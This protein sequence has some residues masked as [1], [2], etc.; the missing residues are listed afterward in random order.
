MH[1]RSLSAFVAVLGIL[2]LSTAAFGQFNL[3]PSGMDGN[4]VPDL[5]YDM[6]TGNITLNSDGSGNIGL[7]QLLSTSGAFTGDA[8]ALPA[9]GLFP[10]DTDME[11]AKAAFA[12]VASLNLGN[13]AQAG[14]D[15]AFLVQ[16]INTAY[17]SGGFGF[18]NITLEL[19]FMGGGQNTAPVGIDDAIT[20]LSGE[21]ALHTFLANDAEGDP[22]TWSNLV[23]NTGAPAVAPTLGADGAFSWDT[24]GS[25]FGEYSWT[26]SVSDGD[27]SGSATLRVDVIPEPTAALLMGLAVAGLA[28]I[29]RK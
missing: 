9:D 26:A 22:L 13:V 20:V 11:I 6:A 8:A 29:R 4:G 24:T 15:A 16:D 19:V 25:A 1:S 14:L 3:I 2:V 21:T 23:L 27:L 18:N 17:V 28:F 5:V 10:V 7:F 12:G